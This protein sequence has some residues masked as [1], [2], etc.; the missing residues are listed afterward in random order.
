MSKPMVEGKGKTARAAE[1]CAAIKETHG[2]A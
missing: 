1:L 2:R